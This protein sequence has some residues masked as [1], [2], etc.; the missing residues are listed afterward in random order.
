MIV[1]T[2]ATKMISFDKYITVHTAGLK[3]NVYTKEISYLQLIW[4]NICRLKDAAKGNVNEI[5][6]VDGGQFHLTLD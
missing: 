5:D 3:I 6:C 1:V 2:M 4:P